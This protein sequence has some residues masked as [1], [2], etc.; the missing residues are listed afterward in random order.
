MHGADERELPTL[1]S[2]TRGAKR[3]PLLLRLTMVFLLLAWVLLAPGGSPGAT[4]VSAVAEP[5]IALGFDHTGTYRTVEFALNIVLFIPIGAGVHLLLRRRVRP[6]GSAVICTVISAGLEA[7]QLLIPGRHA[8]IPDIAANSIGS[9]LGVI[10]IAAVLHWIRT[11]RDTP[12]ASPLS[13]RG[14][15]LRRRGWGDGEQGRPGRFANGA[16]AR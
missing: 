5:L 4:T 15:P 14:G 2:V 16:T 13:R 6:L 7:S 8:T 3:H 12:T 1:A 9:L 10:A 11:H